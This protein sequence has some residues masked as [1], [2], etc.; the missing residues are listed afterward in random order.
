MV[1]NRSWCIDPLRAYFVFYTDPTVTLYMPS[2]DV[3]DYANCFFSRIRDI[4][5]SGSYTTF[6]L[7]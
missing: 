4:I 7:N 5:H 3:A 1:A 6:D 2:D